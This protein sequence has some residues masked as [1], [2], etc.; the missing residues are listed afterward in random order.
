VDGRSL[1][2]GLEFMA[3]F[4]DPNHSWPYS[5][6]HSPKRDEL[7]ELLFRAAA[8]YPD[9]SFDEALKFFNP[10]EFDDSPARLVSKSPSLPETGRADTAGKRFPDSKR[11]GES[12]SVKSADSSGE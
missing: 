12:A 11:L 10:D 2:K 7:G 4:V 9:G 6:I 1:Q 8:I 5:Q 3:Q